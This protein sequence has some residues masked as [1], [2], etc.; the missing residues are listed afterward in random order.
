MG[1][2]G[3]KKFKRKID[4]KLILAFKPDR[5]NERRYYWCKLCKAYH[6]TSQEKRN[7]RSRNDSLA[8]REATKE[9]H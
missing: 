1:A 4:V 5:R 6:L 2:C 7:A 9:D 8:A 3:K